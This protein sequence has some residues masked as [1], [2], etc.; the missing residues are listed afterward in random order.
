MSFSRWHNSL[1]HKSRQDFK[2]SITSLALLA[3][4]PGGAEAAAAAVGSMMCMLVFFVM[5]FIV[6]ILVIVFMIF[7]LVDCCKHEPKMADNQTVM[8]VL[9]I[10]FTGVIGA[11]IYYFVR[12]PH[13]RIGTLY[14]GQYPQPGGSPFAQQSPPQSPPQH[15]PQSDPMFQPYNPSNNPPKPPTG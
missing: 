14:A 15:P 9:L 6:W 11:A 1:I 8:W 13:N 3:Q 2:M 12:R 4:D 5:M 7:M 10:V